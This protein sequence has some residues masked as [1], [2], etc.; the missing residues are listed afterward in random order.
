MYKK[1]KDFSVEI[2]HEE[3]IISEGSGL[4]TNIIKFTFNKID[5]TVP[6]PN[7]MLIRYKHHKK[8]QF[9]YTVINLNSIDQFAE[10]PVF[11]HK[12]LKI[13]F[14]FKSNLFGVKKNVPIGFAAQF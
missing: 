3:E 14:I 7:E 9:K 13:F 4:K 8:D 10:N 1:N 6:V 11:I 5:P 12:L 2:D